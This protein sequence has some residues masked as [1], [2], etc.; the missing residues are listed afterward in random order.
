MKTLKLLSMSLLFSFNLIS[1][2]QSDLFVNEL[3]VS[4]S[5]ET[6]ESIAFEAIE[7]TSNP[8]S[9]LS[10]EEMGLYLMREEEKMAMDI[11]AYF[12]EKYQI[13]IFNNIAK[14][15]SKHTSAVLRLVNYFGLKD[16]ALEPTAEYS[17]EEIQHLYTKL[18][19]EANTIEEALS[20]GAFIEEY[21]I[22]DLKKLIAETQNADIKLVYAN[23]LRGSE[24]HI[25]AFAKQLKFRGIEYVP[26]ILSQEEYNSIINE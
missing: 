8:D 20:T 3:E 14:S 16:P 6:Y 22:A 19:S 21:D 2:E 1:C 10:N 4:T 25:K 24:N 18:T 17:N 15:E 5:N 23:L 9:L 13:P 11:Y 12:Y 26:Q 7:F